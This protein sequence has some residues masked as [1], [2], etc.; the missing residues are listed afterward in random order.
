MFTKS[1]NTISESFDT[2]IGST[3]TFE[4][5]LSA[6]GRVRIDGKINGDVRIN[7]DLMMGETALILGNVSA[8]SIDTAGIIEGNVYC[9]KQLKLASTA[10]LVG[11]IQVE[12]LS[13]EEGGQF[14]GICSM[15]KFERTEKVPE[16]VIVDS[17]ESNILKKKPIITN[18]QINDSIQM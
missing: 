1:G 6:D 18:P 10:K 8:A 14:H 4:G 5:N 9:K 7:G 2:I 12:G 13:I 3:A 16:P 15:S 11:D 17:G